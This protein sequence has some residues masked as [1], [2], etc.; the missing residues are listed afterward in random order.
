MTYQPDY[1][2]GD[3]DVRVYEAITSKSTFNDFVRPRLIARDIRPAA[4]A[5]VRELIANIAP[6]PVH[7]ADCCWATHFAL[8]DQA[9]S[10]PDVRAASWLASVGLISREARDTFLT[11]PG[12]TRTTWLEIP[13]PLSDYGYGIALHEFGHAN[14]RCTAT[15][16]VA[17]DELRAA[18]W[19]LDNARYWTRG[20][21]DAM[22]G[23]LWTYHLFETI[24]RVDFDA[25]VTRAAARELT[26]E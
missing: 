24:S 6:V 26:D 8:T 19:A 15:G 3:I 2:P 4:I 5:H 25:F 13:E 20:L 12:D 9:L 18:Q 10:R 16:A 14:L 23:G 21:T 1:R 7:Y 11:E 22:L 17:G